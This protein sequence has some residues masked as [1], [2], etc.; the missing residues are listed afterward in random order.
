ME[1]RSAPDHFLLSVRS[2][3]VVYW[4]LPHPTLTP[5]PPPLRDATRRPR[6]KGEDVAILETTI[7]LHVLL[8][9]AD[10]TAV[11]FKDWKREK[12]SGGRRRSSREQKNVIISTG[13]R[14]TR[15]VNITDGFIAKDSSG[16]AAIDCR[17]FVSQGDD[18]MNQGGQRRGEGEQEQHPRNL[19]IFLTMGMTIRFRISG[20][21]DFRKG[22]FCARGGH[23]SGRPDFNPDHSC[24]MTDTIEWRGHGGSRLPKKLTI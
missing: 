2:P 20:S 16:L 1:L 11:G 18:G 6:P 14:P 24:S 22:Y 10:S 5:A 9:V 19:S 3:N 4:K 21:P 12:E 17:H 15:G 7:A 23:A 8:D 13:M